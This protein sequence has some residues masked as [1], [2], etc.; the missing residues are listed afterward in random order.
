LHTTFAH[1]RTRSFSISLY[2]VAAF[3]EVLPLRAI[4]TNGPA[5]SG[6]FATADDAE[7][8][9]TNPAGLTRLHE[10]EWVGGISAFYSESDFTTTAQGI[11]GSVSNSNSSSLAIPSIYYARPINSDLTFGISLT[12]PSGLGSDPGDS[13]PGRYLLEKWTLGYVSLTPAAGYRVNEKFSIG[14]GLNLNYALYDYQ[15]AVFNGVGQ[16]DGKMEL[17]DGSFGL[18]YQLGVLYELS[19]MTRLGLSYS[20]S[21]TSSFSSTPSLS[22]LTPQREAL[23][24]AGIRNSP[25]TLE[26]EF[27]QHLG[28]G[29]WHQFPGG[30]SATLDLLWVN[31]NKFG[32]SSATLA[33][34]SIEVTNGRYQNIWGAS[35]GMNWPLDDKWTLRL[36]AAYASSGVDSENRTFS[37]RLDRV[38]GAGVGT[39]YRWHQNR[40]VGVNLSYYNLGGAPVSSTIPLVGTLSGQYSTNYAIGLDL[41]LRWIR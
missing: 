25:V 7:T 34:N 4:A 9:A 38:W 19:P 1:R 6:L 27:P 15:T 35:T 16:P 21:T 32:L 36:G 11:G 37:L 2:V 24:P 31:F 40:I 28:A 10:S 18:G 12:V 13:T 33:N 5:M 14:A 8:A 26:S 22:G 3:A 20:S 30:A 17:R 41:T 29:A 39:L 23:L